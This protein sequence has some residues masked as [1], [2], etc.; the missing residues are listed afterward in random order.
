[1]SYKFIFDTNVLKDDSINK[2]KEAGIIDACS[3]GR[4]SFYATPMLLT[5][6]LSFADQGKINPKA[7]SAVQLLFDIKWQRLFNEFGGQEGILTSELEG[8]CQREFIF[9]NHKFIKNALGDFFEG[10]E[11]NDNAKDIIAADRKRWAMEKENNKNS[12]KAMWDD[13]AQKLKN[14]KF[15]KKDSAFDSFIATTFE[16]TAIYKIN[17]SINSKF[18]KDQIVKFWLAHKDRCPYFNQFIRGRLFTAWH[19]MA[20]EQTPAIDINADDDIQHL[21]YLNGV[22]C[23]VSNESGFMK[24]ACE[25]LF[26]GKDYLSTDQFV[27]RLKNV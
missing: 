20:S 17:Q 27:E 1:M 11:F 21:V 8:K 26:P 19:Y 7:M 13:I 2:F 9:R 25:V 4:F 10:K 23:I 18:P 5:E 24:K 22:D 6:R 16:S 14:K 12:Y 15:S 3:T